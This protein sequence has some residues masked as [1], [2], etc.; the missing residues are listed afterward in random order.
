MPLCGLSTHQGFLSPDVEVRRQNIA[1][2]IASIELAYTLGIPTMRV[3]TGR[4]GTSKSFDDLMKHRGIEP[5]LAGYTDADGF[6]WVIESLEKCLPTASVEIDIAREADDFAGEGAIDGIDAH[7]K[8]VVALVDEADIVFGNGD[9]QTEKLALRD[10]HDGQVLAVGVGA[11][12]DQASKK[13]CAAGSV[14]WTTLRRRISES[15]AHDRTATERTAAARFGSIDGQED[16]QS[17]FGAE[18]R[19]PHDRDRATRVA[20]DVSGDFAYEEAVDGGEAARS[21]DD[22]S[23]PVASARARI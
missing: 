18:I 13:A 11:A 2:T 10:P 5:P 9:A 4:W 15:A 21:D 6:P 16:L 8:L 3:N 12:L 14:N 22:Q 1:K 19:R 17:A 23:A 20:Q 7:V